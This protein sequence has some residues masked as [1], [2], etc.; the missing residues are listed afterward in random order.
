MIDPVS[1]HANATMP[2]LLSLPPEIQKLTR[3]GDIG[4]SADR[5]WIDYATLG[6][7]REHVAD[8]EA[9]LVDIDDFVDLPDT[10]PL[11]R[12][13]MHAWRALAQINAVEAIPTLIHLLARVEQE[14][15]EQVQAE[16][17]LV[18][19]YFGPPAAPALIAYLADAAN[20]AW[21]RLCAAESLTNIALSAPEIRESVIASLHGLLELFSENKVSVNSVLIELLARLKAVEA[22]GLVGRV[23]T[24]GRVD[25]EI[26]ID[27]E[28][29]QVKTGLI[30]QR[31]TSPA[32]LRHSPAAF[33]DD[34]SGTIEPGLTRKV[35]SNPKKPHIA[36]QK[37]KPGKEKKKNVKRKKKK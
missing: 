1:H 31:K 9:I 3:L 13:P 37:T 36:G 12:L 35:K 21:S 26:A 4:P 23:Y 20:P 34:F 14:D 8:L 33:M 24:S 11:Q 18:F 2:D 5:E 22:A 16:L 28:D 17:P 6:I 7:R 32:P 29:F 27:W 10:D 25:P 15:D 19:G 30:E